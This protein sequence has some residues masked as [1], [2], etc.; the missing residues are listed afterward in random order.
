METFYWITRLDNILATVLGLIIIMAIMTIF[1]C[2]VLMAIGMRDDDDDKRDKAK[3]KKVLRITIPSIL[4]LFLVMIFVPSTNEA[5]I[6]YGVGGT[7]DYLKANKTAVGLPDKCIKAI[8]KWADNEINDTAE[9][10]GGSDE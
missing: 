10:K 2:L 5:Y 9:T 7:M 6:I 8:D 4:I 3:S 1:A